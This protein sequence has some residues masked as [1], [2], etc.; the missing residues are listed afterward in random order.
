MR[1]SFLGRVIRKRASWQNLLQPV[2]VLAIGNI[3]HEQ[4]S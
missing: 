1:V 3:I 4:A 2:V